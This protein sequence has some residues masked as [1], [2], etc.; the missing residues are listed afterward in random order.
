[1]MRFRAV[2]AGAL[3][4]ALAVVLWTSPAGAQQVYDGPQWTKFACTTYPLNIKKGAGAQDATLV[5][6]PALMWN[7][8]PIAGKKGKYPRPFAGYVWTESTATDSAAAV[9][10]LATGRKTHNGAIN[11]SDKNR[12]IV[13]TIVE[14]AKALGKKTGTITSVPLSHAT[15]AGMSNAH[16]PSRNQ[17]ADIALQM[18]YGVGGSP[19]KPG[20]V[21]LDVIMGCGHP[22]F[23][24]DGRGV[25]GPAAK[26][27]KYV[28]GPEAWAD[29][30]AGA[31]G[32]TSSGFAVLHAKADFKALAG[33][34]SAGGRYLGIPE[35]G[36]T[37]QERRSGAS[38]DDEPF[39]DPLNPRVPTLETMTRAALNVLDGTKA[40]PN[41]AGFFLHVEGG[42]V[43]WAN[44]AN[45][46]GRC[47]EEQIDFN[48]SVRVV[49]DYLDANTN[50]NN[51]SNTL[52]VLTADHDCGFLLGPDADKK[53]YPLLGNQ[54]RGKLPAYTYMWGGHTNSL[55]PLY[56]RGAGSELF[57]P[58]VDGRDT[59][60]VSRYGLW[61][62]FDGR[63][64]DNT[65][66]F[67]A[68]GGAMTT[69]RARNVILMISDGAGFNIWTAATMYE[70]G[71]PK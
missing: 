27:T 28:G 71:L 69:G 15:P 4:L 3:T 11:W 50:G 34:D 66:I 67:A 33:D 23:D 25:K 40:A 45:L 19:K 10:A 31:G 57:A 54:G 56:A 49:S 20:K 36:S 58:L 16:A 62:G 18:V 1:M 21:M 9:T 30:G 51:W 14:A 6:K 17:Y 13:P 26:Q 22:G 12:P 29:M 70:F 46:L 68:M 53:A 32:R 48:K 8:T 52:V 41:R 47:V 35:V 2:L 60:L 24:N 43:D 59:Q 63:Y 42:A 39:A 37:L 61:Q 65:D 38:G 64:V 5:Y 44:H 7:T 55:V